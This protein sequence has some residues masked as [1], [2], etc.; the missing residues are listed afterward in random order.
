MVGKTIM[1]EIKMNVKTRQEKHVVTAIVLA[2]NDWYYR[3]DTNC[4]TLA[5]RYPNLRVGD[6]FYQE[7][8][9]RHDGSWSWF[10]TDAVNSFLKADF[11]A[12][13]AEQYAKCKNPLSRWWFRFWL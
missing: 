4:E 2:N 3:T 7:K 1:D 9:Q 13:K 5:H 11:E 6:T 12:R 8:Y 10:K